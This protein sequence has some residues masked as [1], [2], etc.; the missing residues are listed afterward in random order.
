MTTTGFNTDEMKEAWR[1]TKVS[2]EGYEEMLNMV[3][4]SKRQTTL[5]KL[6]ARYRRFSIMA[7]V[8]CVCS[9]PYSYLPLVPPER[10]FWLMAIFMIFFATASVM[11]YW[12]Y[13]RIS[14]I[15]VYSMGVAEVAETAV[16]C[17]KRHHQFML[18]L[19]PMAMVVLGYML[20]CVQSGPEARSIVIG[21]GAGF[22]TGAAVGLRQYLQFMRD[23]R[24][25]SA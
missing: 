8:C 3:A 10:R 19:I 15:D 21:M 14:S 16:T 5:Q 25:L 1:D 11:D 9:V 13:L 6:S 2:R 24:T 20:S 7:M 4:M 18:I 17:R 12:L 23:Y 22:I